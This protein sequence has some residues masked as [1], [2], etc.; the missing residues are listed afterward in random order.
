MWTGSRT[1]GSSHGHT[2]NTNVSVATAAT[3]WSWIHSIDRVDRPGEG[4]LYRCRSS[5]RKAM[6]PV[7]TSTASPGSTVI[8]AAA[9][10]ASRSSPVIA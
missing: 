9:A 6:W 8:P 5:G 1:F 7:R 2:S 3:S 4:W 10:A